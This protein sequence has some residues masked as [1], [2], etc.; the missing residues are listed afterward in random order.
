MQLVDYRNGLVHARSS[1]P[2]TMQQSD[3]AKPLPSK[4]TLL[5]SAMLNTGAASGEGK[6][7]GDV[8]RGKRLTQARGSRG[9]SDDSSGARL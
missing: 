7:R 2:E 5:E 9:K 4:T 6:S 8:V 1:R 3:Q